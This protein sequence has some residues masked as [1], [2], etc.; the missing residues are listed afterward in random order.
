M[1]RR[2]LAVVLFVFSALF[3]AACGDDGDEGSLEDQVEQSGDSDTTEADSG[4]GGDSG[5][6]GDGGDGETDATSDVS[7]ALDELDEATDD[8]GDLGEGLDDMP[9]DLGDLGEGLEDLDE[10]MDSGCL[11]FSLAYASVFLSGLGAFGGMSEEE[12]EQAQADLQ[13]LQASVPD[14]LQEDFATVA[15]AYSSYFEELAGSTLAEMGELED[16]MSDP[17]VAAAD[18]NI[19]A[20]IEENCGG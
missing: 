6:S 12:V 10:F 14:E 16:P 9:G 1:R 4:D 8:L 13:E 5:D 17:D 20:W 7:E 18:E 19:N 2:S 15:D 3:L 11:E